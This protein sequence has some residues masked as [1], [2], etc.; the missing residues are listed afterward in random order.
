MKVGQYHV[1]M[2]YETTRCEIPKCIEMELKE[3]NFR[4]KT[5]FSANTIIIV[6]FRVKRENTFLAIKLI[7]TVLLIK[8]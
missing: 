1:I 6:E 8:I 4:F 3:V 2:Q 7:A 5:K